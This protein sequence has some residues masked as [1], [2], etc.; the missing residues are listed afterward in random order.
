MVP[1]ILKL[2]ST[3]TWIFSKKMKCFSQQSLEKRPFTH[4]NQ[5]KLSLGEKLLEDFG[6]GRLDNKY[7]LHCTENEGNLKACDEV[8]ENMK[9]FAVKTIGVSEVEA[10]KMA[11]ERMSKLPAWQDIEKD[12]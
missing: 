7:C 3:G 10:L 2:Y 5:G 4:L 6:S 12:R 8:L 11:Q 9:A 1:T